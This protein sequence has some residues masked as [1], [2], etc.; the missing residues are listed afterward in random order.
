MA[1]TKQ[2]RKGK[3]C[4]F[5]RWLIVLTCTL[6]RVED[7]KLQDPDDVFP[8]CSPVNMCTSQSVFK[9]STSCP[10]FIFYWCATTNYRNFSGLKWQW[11]IVS[12]FSRSEIQESSDGDP[13]LGL[14]RS[15]SRCKPTYLLSRG[16][17]RKSTCRS[18]Q[19]VGRIWF[20]AIIGRGSCFLV[21][22]WLEIVHSF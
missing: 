18:I 3:K 20:H 15:K 6:V 17:G 12:Q 1:T 8:N 4:G 11:F 14:T 16:S 21:D 5:F 13:T 2:K 19:I 10:W 7:L 9:A 22:W